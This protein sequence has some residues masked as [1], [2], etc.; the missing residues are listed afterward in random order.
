MYANFSG[1]FVTLSSLPHGKIGIA[2]QPFRNGVLVTGGQADT[3]SKG[4]WV[5]AFCY[6]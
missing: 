1:T 4:G 3:G 6:I 2:C 5:T